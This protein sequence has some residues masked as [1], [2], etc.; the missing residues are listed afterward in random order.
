MYENR[1]NKGI[2]WI[3]T[4]IGGRADYPKSTIKTV[5]FLIDVVKGQ[6]LGKRLKDRLIQLHRNALFKELNAQQKPSF[7]LPANYITFVS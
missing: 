3:R 5:L 7:P 2:K 1:R 4:Q 6:V